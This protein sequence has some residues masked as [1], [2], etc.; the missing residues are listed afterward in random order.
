M[1][2][3]TRHHQTSSSLSQT[4][5]LQS[6]PPVPLP[7]LNIPP[8]QIYLDEPESA[9]D[10][11]PVG[12]NIRMEPTSSSRPSD[13]PQ[14]QPMY[15]YLRSRQVTSANPPAYGSS[16]NANGMRIVTD[17]APTLQEP[18][19][20][21][22]FVISVDSSPPPPSYQEIF[23]QHEIEMDNMQRALAREVDG[24]PAEQT[25]DIYK[26]IVAMLLIVLT[27]ACVGTAFNWG[28]PM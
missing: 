1:A 4:R 22:P 14:Y 24:D 23:R 20:D 10:D 25:E 7:Q 26:W 12:D 27:I 15:D 6:L 11:E 5:L 2:N 8:P 9:D 13:P 21:E 17:P 28:R 16:P 3:R 19:R 18:Y